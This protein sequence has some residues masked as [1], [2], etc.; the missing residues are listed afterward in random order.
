MPFAI[1]PWN[2]PP[3]PL[4]KQSGTAGAAAKVTKHLLWKSK[5][6][7][8]DKT[9][10]DM[11]PLNYS[12]AEGPNSSTTHSL[13]VPGN[14]QNSDRITHTLQRKH[15]KRKTLRQYVTGKSLKIGDN[16]CVQPSKPHAR[17]WS[18]VTVSIRLTDRLYEIMAKNGKIFT[19]ATDVFC[20][21]PLVPPTHS[22][23]KQ[24]VT[25]VKELDQ[26]YEENLIPEDRASIHENEAT[27]EEEQ[28][29]NNR[30][31]QVKLF[32]NQLASC[33]KAPYITWSRTIFFFILTVSYHPTVPPSYTHIMA[34]TNP[35]THMYCN[36]HTKL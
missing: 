10:G 22:H 15:K 25:P 30:H 27:L 26:K 33:L 34:M 18:K 19:D 16:A 9:V 32:K 21:K 35:M 13:I 17:K 23:K 11:E 14:R 5:A 3:G 6:S 36:C 12:S 1:R 29:T 24:R 28:Q 8:Y 4:G 2:G 31:G 7:G 20:V